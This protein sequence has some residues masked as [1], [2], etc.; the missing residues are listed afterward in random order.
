MK[1]FTAKV[2]TGNGSYSKVKIQAETRFN[3]EKLLKMQYG[4]KNVYDV[5]EE[6][7]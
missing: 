2:R 4:E 1:T 7:S 6:H 5:Q 3:A